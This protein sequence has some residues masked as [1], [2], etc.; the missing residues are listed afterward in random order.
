MKQFLLTI[1]FAAVCLVPGIVLAQGATTA[2]ISGLV[3]SS[4][5]ETLPGA[6]IVAVHGPTGTQYGTVSRADGRFNLPNVRTG[7]PYTISVSFVGYTTQQKRDINLALGQEFNVNFTLSED[8]DELAEVVVTAVEDPTFNSG[9]TGAAT[10]ISKEQLQTLPTLSRSLGDFTRLTPQANGNSFGGVSNRY[11]NITIDGA[12]NNDVFGLAGSGTP[13]GQAGTQPIS[14][15]A[16]QEIQV[17]LAPYD[18]TLGNFTG[19]GVNAITRS[20]TNDFNGSVYYFGRNENTIG[21]DPESGEEAA[22]FSDYQYGA[23]LGGP[24]IKNKLFFFVNADFTRRAQPIA[25]NAGEEGAVL[26]VTDAQAITNYLVNSYGYNPGVFGPI[27]AATE[28]NKLFGRLDWNIT[29]NHQLTLRHNYVKAFDD[30]ISR[31]NTSFRFGNNAYQFNNTTNSTVAELRSQFSNTLSNKLIVGYSRIRDNRATAGAPFPQIQIFGFPGGG[32]VELGSQRSSTANELDQD[33]FEFTDNF[34]IYSG[35]HTFTVGTHNEFFTFRNL[36]IN[37]LYG[38][39]DF[40]SLEDFYNN[41]PSRV[42]STYSLDP[43]NPR[44]AASFSASQLGFYVQD[45]YAFNRQFTVTVGLRLDV[46]VI[47]DT[48]PANQ[49]FANTFEGQ[50]T[51]RTPSGQLLW[52]PRVGFNWDATGD[53]SVQVRGGTGVFTGRVP[54]VWLSNQFSNSGGLFGTVDVRGDNINGGNGFEPDPLRQGANLGTGPT[55][56]EVNAVSEDFKIPQVWRSNLAADFALPLGIVATVE[57]IYSKTL[58]NIL[59]QDINLKASDGTLD[60]T[61]TGGADS[62]VVFPAD[63]RINSAFTNAIFLSNSN[64]GYTYSLT[65]QLRK[66][67]DNGIQSMIAY[68]YGKAKDVNSGNSSTAA[69]NWEFNQVVG[70]PN[71]PELSYSAYDLRHRIVGNLGYRLEYG[72]N[73]ATTISLFYSGRSG[74]PFTYLYNGDL[75]RDGAFQNDLLYIPANASEITFEPLTTGGVTYSPQEQW[76]AFNNFIE[77]DEYLSSRRGQYAERNGARTPWEH[78]LDLRLMQDFFVNIA[79]KRNAFQLTF[80]VFNLGNMLNDEWGRSYFISNNSVTLVNFDDRN[81]DGFTFNP[82]TRTEPWAVSAFASRWQGQ[83][84]LR[85]IFG[86]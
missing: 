52:A 33:I 31:S 11:N 37:N 27:T 22:D 13:G 78:Q 59:Y 29:S 81:R 40:S 84:G 30:N 24:I 74:T 16:I 2:S 36:F 35:N 44:P 66:N 51:D 75:N 7:G 23:R 54:F 50:R 20:G 39:W 67:F 4:T 70:D 62:R 18:I 65:G 21:S 43:N 34:K 12:V 64:E 72:N 26:S 73:F 60:P 14:L 79:G 45:E 38:R 32:S 55:T 19:G 15:D 77:N 83:I 1:L 17:V 56:Y 49:E 85:Y 25:Y 76:E 58:N 80:D 61:L 71:N 69:S 3:T 68:T 63:R 42:R 47:P 53:R 57:G 46:P 5:G 48:P 41:N 8:A 82:N 28:S 86:E 9:R 6:N 10:N